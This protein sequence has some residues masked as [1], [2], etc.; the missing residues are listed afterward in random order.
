MESHG[1]RKIPC[2]FL[3][4]CV[5]LKI[6]NGSPLS[7]ALRDHLPIDHWAVSALSA[8]EIAIKYSLGKLRLDD[9]PARWWPKV[10]ATLQVDVIHFIADIALLA[11]S[12]PPLRPFQTPHHRNRP[13]PTVSFSQCR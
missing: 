6:T 1:R 4:T 13:A 12:L 3:D 9:V 7:N 5:L 11:G 8:W 2:D 10:A